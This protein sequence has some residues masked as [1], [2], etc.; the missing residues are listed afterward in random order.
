[1]SKRG[2][3]VATLAATLMV[4]TH[5]P[6]A[7]GQD[8]GSGPVLLPVPVDPSTGTNA[9]LRP[10][11]QPDYSLRV[12][13][14][15]LTPEQAIN[16]DRSDVA[17]EMEA[18]R[19]KVKDHMN[20]AKLGV[21]EDRVRFFGSQWQNCPPVIGWNGVVYKVAPIKGGYA[22]TLQITAGM[23]GG[24]TDSLHLFEH[25]TIVGG[26]VKYRGYTEPP[27]QLRHRGG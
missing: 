3:T 19:E 14:G 5:L 7:A 15:P 27:A 4:M 2:T 11:P 12:W 20:K 13:V 6:L 21:P 26:K 23:A 25:Y 9:G 16:P 17:K 1:M 22:V 10:A 8:A 18:L 24:A